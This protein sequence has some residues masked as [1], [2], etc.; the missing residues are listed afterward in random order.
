MARGNPTVVNQ[1]VADIAPGISYL[2][3]LASI[4]LVGD[5]SV[6][7]LTSD[8]FDFLTGSKMWLPVDRSR[9]SRCVEAAVYGALDML[10]FPRFPAPV[11]YI[12]AVIASYVSQSR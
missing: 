8:D 11:E 1:P 6:L 12:A 2:T 7:D 9:A 4:K 3:A 5:S 10:G